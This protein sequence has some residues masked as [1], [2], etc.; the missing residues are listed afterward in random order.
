ML[1]GNARE[2]GAIPSERDRRSW[3]SLGYVLGMFGVVVVIILVILV[4]F[5]ESL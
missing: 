1:S 4:I 2:G 3:F 5:P